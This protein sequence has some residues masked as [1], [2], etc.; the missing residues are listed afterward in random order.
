MNRHNTKLNT[1][2]VLIAAICINPLSAKY[3]QSDP[4]GQKAGPNTYNYVQ[5][6]P[7][8][9]IDPTGL[10]VEATY[11]K[12]SGRVVMRDVDT[13]ATTSAPAFSGVQNSFSPTPNG[14]YSISHFPW[15]K[16]HYYA[17]IH[18]D[19]VIDDYVDGTPSNYDPTKTMSN[20][21][22]HPGDTSH[23]C[24]TIPLSEDSKEWMAIEEMIR[25]TQRG[26]PIT[27]GGTKYPNFGTLNVTGSGFG[28]VPGSTNN[29]PPTSQ[30]PWYERLWN[31]ITGE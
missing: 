6:N 17:L 30:Q 4:L 9:N 7:I 5:S 1:F 19:K 2:F 20:I 8:I 27:I 24:V 14:T 29:Q 3:L 31:W 15:L 26:T 21:R 28:S 16:P 22:L 18:H 25:N 13:G 12:T 11:D 23:A 10:I